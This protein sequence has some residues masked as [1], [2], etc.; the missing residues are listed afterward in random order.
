MLE[1]IEWFRS[2]PSRHE[3]CIIILLKNE[4]YQAISALSSIAPDEMLVRQSSCQKL[5]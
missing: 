1:L 5:K 3:K 4:Q 2:I